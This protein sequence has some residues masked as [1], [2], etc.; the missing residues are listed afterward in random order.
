MKACQIQ[1]LFLPPSFKPIRYFHRPFHTTSKQDMP[2][3]RCR[4]I[5]TVKGTFRFR[6]LSYC[7]PYSDWDSMNRRTTS[8]SSSMRSHVQML[9]DTSS[10]S[11]S[12]CAVARW[13]RAQAGRRGLDGDDD[14][15]RWKDGSIVLRLAN[16]VWIDNRKS[17]H[18]ASRGSSW[19]ETRLLWLLCDFVGGWVAVA[20][21]AVVVD[22]G[23][24]LAA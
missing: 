13:K 8:R 23:F 6:S 24:V 4:T 12:G 5:K 18:R 10:R 22:V 9:S 21:A 1:Q 2:C 19:R 7:S 3:L 20:V 11:V 17:Y 15:R 14:S 16:E